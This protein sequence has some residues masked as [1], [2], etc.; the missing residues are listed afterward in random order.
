MEHRYA[1]R[2]LCRAVSLGMALLS[3]PTGALAKVTYAP[4]TRD[5]DVWTV[6]GTQYDS[7]DAAN[8]AAD[9]KRPGFGAVS[10]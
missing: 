3:A 5:V 4:S 9:A 7:E 8:A 6:E 10:I 2:A 1:R